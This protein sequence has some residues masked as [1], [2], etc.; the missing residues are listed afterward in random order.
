MNFSCNQQVTGCRMQNHPLLQIDSC[1]LHSFNTLFISC[2]KTGIPAH[3]SMKLANQRFW[4]QLGQGSLAEC[5][6]KSVY[7]LIVPHQHVRKLFS[8]QDSRYFNLLLKVC[9]YVLCHCLK[10][11]ALR[12]KCIFFFNKLLP[13]NH[14][15][16]NIV[17]I[18]NILQILQQS[19]V[20]LLI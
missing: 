15:L 11:H 7:I 8:S 4:R 2:L 1:S 9:D 12:L 13:C 16:K 20:K 18:M 19:E 6:K 5:K 10:C 17:L 14:Y 3:R